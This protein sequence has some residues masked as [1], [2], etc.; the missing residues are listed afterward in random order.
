MFGQIRL[1]CGQQGNQRIAW[2]G[3]AGNL[4]TCDSAVSGSLCGEKRRGGEDVVEQH[5]DVGLMLL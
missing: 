1:T 4:V 3:S 2:V 5:I